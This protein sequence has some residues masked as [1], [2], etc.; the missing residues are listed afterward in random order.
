MKKKNAVKFATL[1]VAGTGILAT[2]S[3]KNEKNNNQE[4]EQLEQ[5]ETKENTDNS[6]PTN[7]TA[8]Y[9]TYIEQNN[10]LDS[11]RT[12]KINTK[13]ALQKLIAAVQEKSEALKA[14]PNQELDS[15]TENMPDSTEISTTVIKAASLKKQ[16]MVITQQL[17]S[18]QKNYFEDLSESVANLK[19]DVNELSQASETSFDNENIQ[20]FFED[21]A[22]VLEEMVTDTPNGNVEGNY[23]S[24]DSLRYSQKPDT[25]AVKE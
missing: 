13:I 19:E 16:A 14:T 15:L 5:Y 21:A 6:Y 12:Q 10:D 23:I 3:C 1:V 24:D 22:D 8:D 18:L 25:I 9:L 11:A 2:T 4:V 20:D 17:E 7:A